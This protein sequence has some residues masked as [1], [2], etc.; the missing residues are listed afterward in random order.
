[1]LSRA[2]TV[3]HRNIKEIRVMK[4]QHCALEDRIETTIRLPPAKRAID[5]G[6]VNFLAPLVVLF[7]G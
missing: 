6:V 2:V 3:D 4:R 7:D 1:M 5:A